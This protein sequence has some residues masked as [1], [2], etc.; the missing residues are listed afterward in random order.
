VEDFLERERLRDDPWALKLA[1]AK[2]VDYEQPEF[3]QEETASPVRTKST[4]KD[5]KSRK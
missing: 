5:S 4:K 1:R 3:S 2:L